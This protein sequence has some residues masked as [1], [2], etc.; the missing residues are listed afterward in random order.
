M[1]NP[2][3]IIT[4]NTSSEGAGTPTYV[5]NRLTYT[6]T[7]PFEGYILI[8]TN[9]TSGETYTATPTITHNPSNE[10][11]FTLIGGTTTAE[12]IVKDTGVIAVIVG[13]PEI[14]TEGDSNIGVQNRLEG[15]DND[16]ST[17]DSDF[18]LQS[19]TI[20]SGDTTT[21]ENSDGLSSGVIA[22]S[23]L[24]VRQLLKIIEPLGFIHPNVSTNTL[25]F[26][27]NSVAKILDYNTQSA[28][29]DN[30]NLD[31]SPFLFNKDNISQGNILNINLGCPIGLISHYTTS[32]D[33]GGLALSAGDYTLKSDDTIYNLDTSGNAS[34]ETITKKIVGSLTNNI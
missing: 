29:F 9:R 19:R 13:D 32:F 5:S 17:S 7:Q 14:E 28:N 24:R 16:F 27:T 4:F 10:N 18:S 31:N 23:V 15:P 2:T 11:S 21:R 8:S 22:S 12:I 25:E 33:S 26:S 20:A 6:F 3:K 1:D 30:S 34:G